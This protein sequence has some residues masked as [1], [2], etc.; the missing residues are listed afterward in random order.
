MTNTTNKWLRIGA[1][2]ALLP[3][4][5]CDTGALFEVDSPGKIADDNLNSKDAI[6]GIVAGVSAEIADMMGDELIEFSV[7][8]SGEMFH[9][10]SYDWADIP[11]GIILDEDVNNTWEEMHQARWVAQDAVRRMG[12]EILSE[13]EFNSSPFVARALLFGGI[14]NRTLGEHV[15]F[16]VFDGEAPQPHTVHFQRA[17]EQL[18]RA[19]QIGQAA[20]AGASDIVTAAYGARASVRVSLGN[21][22]GAVEDA[23][24]VPVEFVYLAHLNTESPSNSL[25]YETHNR[26]EYSVFN[27]EFAEHPEDKR[28]VWHIEYKADGS[29][30]TGANG[31]T[32]HYQQDKYKNFG[33]DVPLVKGT[34]MLLIRAEA[35][36]RSNDLAQ[37]RDLMNQARAFYGMG[38]LEASATASAA[39]AWETLHFERGATL[40]LENRRLGDL[41]RWNAE[42]GPAHH[43][44]LDNRDKCVPISEE[45]KRA[46]PNARG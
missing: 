45:E 7:L 11:R 38:P 30:A 42:S 40:W 3:L 16:A 25:F 9:G 46:N 22:A 8:A 20:G 32:P 44:F 39:A 43:T 37:A 15:C 2:A 36:L 35:A 27:T 12:E 24:R 31:S 4:A 5:A 13:A 14:A 17:E 10:G 23:A 41:R 33:A 21:W 34:E 1:L 19:I 18:T 29:V 28:A 26:F 6:P